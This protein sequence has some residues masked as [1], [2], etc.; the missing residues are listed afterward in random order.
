MPT[1]TTKGRFQLGLAIVAI[2]VLVS[3]AIVMSAISLAYATEVKKDDPDRK[4]II[5]LEVGVLGAVVFAAI[6][7][8]IALAKGGR[9]LQF[10]VAM[11]ARTPQQ[12]VS[13]KGQLKKHFMG[14]KAKAKRILT[15]SPLVAGMTPGPD[16]YDGFAPDR[17]DGFDDGVGEIGSRFL[18]G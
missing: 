6:I 12:R 5:G 14:A 11:A 3:A 15:G 4:R 8:A 13:R 9:C 10:H 17:Y 18:K 16:R 7:T 1:V 2:L